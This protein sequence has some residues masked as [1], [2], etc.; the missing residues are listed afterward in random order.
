MASASRTGL[1]PSTAHLPMR[2]PLRSLLPCRPPRN[3]R[4]A[5]T[6]RVWAGPLSLAATRG[7]TVVLLSSAYLDV[8]VRRVRPHQR[9][10]PHLPCGGFPH[11]GTRGSMAARASPRPFA[12]C[13]ALRRLREPQASPVRPCSTR[14]PRP[15]IAARIARPALVSRVSL[16]S[17]LRFFVSRILSMNRAP[18]CGRPAPAAGLCGGCG[19]RTH[20][21]RLAKPVL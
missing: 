12:A 10:V 3:P 5:S 1:S 8:S 16:S 2:V 4:R 6:P 21:P 13:R 11:S 7:V 20:D 17:S 14:S 9:W 19:A 15:R 18:L